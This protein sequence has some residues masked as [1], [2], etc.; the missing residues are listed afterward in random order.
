MKSIYQLAILILL[1]A[2]AAG[3]VAATVTRI[4]PNQLIKPSPDGTQELLLGEQDSFEFAA[5]LFS[6]SASLP[7]SQGQALD[8]AGLGPG[9]SSLDFT[10]YVSVRAPA[11]VIK[12]G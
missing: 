5:G 4:S 10:L 12:E 1:S 9:R 7:I 2:A 6:S 8:V 11:F 3:P